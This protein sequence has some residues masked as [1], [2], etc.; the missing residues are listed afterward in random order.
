MRAPHR[1]AHG[2][3]AVCHFMAGRTLDATPVHKHGQRKY[4]DSGLVILCRRHGGCD[5][6]T[7]TPQ[8][9]G[10]KRKIVAYPNRSRSA[11]ID[12]VGTELNEP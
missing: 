11:T 5:M 3:I 2:I 9:T 12:F 6:A 4:Q 7:T 10:T 1:P 8:I